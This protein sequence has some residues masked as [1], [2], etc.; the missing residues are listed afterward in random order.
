MLRLAS[1]HQSCFNPKSVPVRGINCHNPAAPTTS[2]LA[3][4][5]GITPFTPSYG[6]GY[7]GGYSVPQYTPNYGVN[8]NDWVDSIKLKPYESRI[9]KFIL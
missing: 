5:S 2:P 4:G 7:S 1:N 8:E 3:A 9:Y 6:G